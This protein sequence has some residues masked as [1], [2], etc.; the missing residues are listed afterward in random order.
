[1]IDPG[2]F[3]TAALLVMLIYQQ[4]FFLRQ[5]QTLVDKATSQSFESYNRALNPTPP[6]A[7]IDDG[8]SDDMGSLQE[9]Q[10]HQI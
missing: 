4:W 8:P 6:R 10:L 1:M 2:V 9:F 7:K 5:I 3:T